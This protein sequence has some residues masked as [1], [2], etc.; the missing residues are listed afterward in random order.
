MS[1]TVATLQQ[2]ILPIFSHVSA[3][4]VGAREVR[5]IHMSPKLRMVLPVDITPNYS[6]LAG[7]FQNLS[8][9]SILIA[10]AAPLTLL[11]IGN[12]IERPQLRALASACY[13]HRQRAMK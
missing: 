4:R 10:Q 12:R 3:T 5:E 1:G 13:D 9:P 11:R 6:R 8:T 7:V 2:R